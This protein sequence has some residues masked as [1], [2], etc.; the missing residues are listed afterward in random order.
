VTASR[1]VLNRVTAT[2][3]LSALR[4]NLAC[5][6]RYAPCARVMA[7]VK[8]NAYGHGAVPVARALAQAGADALAVACLEEAILLRDVG[9]QAPVTLLEGV[10][11]AEELCESTAL[12]LQLVVHDEFQLGLLQRLPTDQPVSL[13]FKF[14]SGMH[15]L[16]FPLAEA[17][18][19][20][21]VLAAHPNWQLQGWMTHL[22]CADELDNDMTL[23]QITAFDTALSGL[24][25]PRSIANSAGLLAWPAARRDWVRPGLMLYGASPLPG[26]SAVELGLRPVMQLSSR[27]LSIHDVAAG[28]SIG[29]GARFKCS[30][31]MRIGVVAV[32][33]ADGVHRVLPS[34][35]PTLIRGQTAPLVGRVSMDMIC[36][37]LAAVPG[38]CVGDPVVLWGEGLPAETVAD[39]AQTLAYELFCG[40]TQR[41][42]FEYVE[43]TSKPA[44]HSGGNA[45]ATA[46]DAKRT[47]EVS[48][49]VPASA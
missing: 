15:R 41:V 24:P 27:L 33:Y 13:W 16:G 7:P 9:I 35:T 40:L 28:E 34:G 46:W 2:V 44:G 20:A 43:S 49:T 11:S 10:L 5:V 29:Y 37:D 48:A 8:A 14:D 32:G 38:A 45:D 23:R 39:Y 25:G 36:V 42:H 3:D 17:S 21:A 6:R 30:R 4:D 22:A 12:G 47:A 26:R 19:L 31:P 18:R 1:T